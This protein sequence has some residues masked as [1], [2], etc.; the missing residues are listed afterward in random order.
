MSPVQYC[1]TVVLSPIP[2][3]SACHLY[4][5]S[6]HVTCTICQCMSRVQYIHAAQQVCLQCVLSDEALHLHMQ[7]TGLSCRR[8]SQGTL[9][10][11][12]AKMKKDRVPDQNVG[13]TN[14]FHTLES[15][16][17]TFSHDCASGK[18]LASCNTQLPSGAHP[19][20]Q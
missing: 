15:E 10:F 20:T 14:L 12:R 2:F 6:V 13:K 4:H 17:P 9:A 18:T 3:V 19:N 5:L 7:H 8:F 16:N 1:Q 11:F